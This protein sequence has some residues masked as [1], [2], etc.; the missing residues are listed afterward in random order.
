[1]RVTVRLRLA[2]TAA[3]T[4]LAV[5]PVVP[6]EAASSGVN[7]FSCQ[8]S[9]AHPE[10]V[11][12]LH[13]LSS[14][15]DQNWSFHGPRIAAAGYCVFSVTYGEQY[16]GSGGWVPIAESAQ[17]IGAFIDQVLAATGANKVN[18]VGHS[19]GAFQSLYVPKVAGYAP[20]VSRV[21]ALAPPTHGTTAGGLVTLGQTLGGQELVTLFT[22]GFSCRACT[23]LVD[24]GP[25]VTAL[26]D[27]PI[28]QPGVT[29]TV[30]SSKYDAVVTPVSTGFVNEPGVTNYYV[31]DKCLFDPVGHIGIAVD[32]GVTSMILNGLDPAVRISCGFGPPF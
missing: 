2:L 17:E 15:K 11:V 16:P 24:G 10:P 19:E 29:Y 22:D 25:A 21:V 32:P 6:A 14:N 18:L 5:A 8:P 4:A 13:G 9:A 20:K 23:D 31:Q 30:I 26:T 3:A 12:L 1:M 28:A 7:D 27:G